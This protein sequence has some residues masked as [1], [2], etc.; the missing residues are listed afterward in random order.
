VRPKAK[1]G[2]MMV[3]PTKIPTVPL[4]SMITMTMAMIAGD[5]LTHG[6]DVAGVL[7]T[8]GLLTVID[9]DLLRSRPKTHLD[10]KNTSDKN[11]KRQLGRRDI[12]KRKP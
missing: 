9:G 10:M 12:C 11:K 3:V 8:L 4:M 5:R 7:V 1:V 2:D 6:V